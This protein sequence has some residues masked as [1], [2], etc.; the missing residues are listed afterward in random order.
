VKQLD[1]TRPVTAAQSGAMMN[2]VNAS[3]AADV[4]GFNYGQGGY[5]RYHAAHPGKPMTSSED[6]SAV[7][8]RGEYLTDK[9]GRFVIDGYDD[10][11]QPWGADHRA[12]WRA[13][14]TRPFV[15]GTFVWTGFDYRGEPQPLAW[16][17]TG[18]SFG[19]MDQCGFPKTAF[20]IHQAEW[21]TDRPVL[22]LIP[23]WNWPGQEGKP[24]KV[25]AIT[26]AAEVE[27]RLNGRPVG[28]RTRVDPIDVTATWQVPYAPGKLEAVGYRDGKEVSRVA[29]ETTGD[30]VALRL[31][32]DRSALA[33]D[34]RDAMPVTV[35]AVDAQGRVV[36]TAHP[37]AV[38]TASAS[39]RVIGV[40]NG[41]PIDHEPDTADRRTLYNGL[42]QVI[43]QSTAGGTQP[44]TLTAEAD[45]LRAAA[46]TV[47]VTPVPAVAVVPVEPPVTLVRG[48]RQSPATDARPDPSQPVGKTDMNTYTAVFP[49]T[50]PPLVGGRF[51]LLR[52]AFTA[53]AD[54]RQDGGQLV[55]KAFAGRA[56]VY[57]D[58]H[59]AG[60]K[61]DPAV[62]PFRVPVPAGDLGH[63]VV[64]VLEAEPGRAAGLAGA[65]M[66]EAADHPR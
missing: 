13:V 11:H 10:Q 63:H 9:Q 34:G 44:I 39:G 49:G 17:S 41:D 33:D 48:W 45:G 57:L 35:Q 50:A 24:V 12:A 4:A 40:A 61:A 59:P 64:I 16:P 38:F 7:M 22:Q 66:V 47:M 20:Y 5:D 54:V 56:D 62:A 1:P 36:P 30:P 25:M 14:A 6:T 18:S 8:T 32:P 23:H 51:A 29:V 53:R 27:L 60:H 15:A 55:F 28:D 21:V 52:A 31:V 42:A 58:G 37:S 65:V 43:L 3:L 26:N 2:V 46:L 19:C